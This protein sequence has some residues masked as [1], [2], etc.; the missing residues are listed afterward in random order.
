[1][2]DFYDTSGMV[3]G[4]EDSSNIFA[5]GF[6]DTGQRIIDPI[7]E[8]IR[9]Q[10]EELGYLRDIVLYTSFSGGSGSA[11]ASLLMPRLNS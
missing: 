10:A 1:M 7:M 4:R 11:L 9:L 3:Y 2:R 6:Y 8:N 5:R